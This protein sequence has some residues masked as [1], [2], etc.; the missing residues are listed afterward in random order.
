MILLRDFCERESSQF[1]QPLALYGAKWFLIVKWVC[2]NVI[3]WRKLWHI[4]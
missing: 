1:A 3:F 2:R 4:S